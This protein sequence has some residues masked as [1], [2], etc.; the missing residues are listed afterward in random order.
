M[1]S[2]FAVPCH[3]WNRAMASFTNYYKEEEEEGV[4]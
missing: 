1:T 2:I 3:S 4:H